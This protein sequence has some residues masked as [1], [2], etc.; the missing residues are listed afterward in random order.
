M[1]YTHSNHNLAKLGSTGYQCIAPVCMCGCVHEG[2]PM[3]VNVQNTLLMIIDRANNVDSTK[4]VNRAVF[5]FMLTHH[6]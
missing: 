6:K 3:P 5:C 4:I 2:A 1:S